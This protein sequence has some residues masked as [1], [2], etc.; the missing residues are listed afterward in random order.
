MRK[1][2]NGLKAMKHNWLNTKLFR[3]LTQAFDRRGDQDSERRSDLSKVTE[4]QLAK[5]I[6]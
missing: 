6:S 3:S 2:P 4:L 5:V 1:W